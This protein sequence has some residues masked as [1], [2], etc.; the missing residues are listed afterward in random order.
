MVGAQKSSSGVHPVV[1]NTDA[2]N[3]PTLQDRNAKDGVCIGVFTDEMA[4]YQRFALKK[5][6]VRKQEEWRFR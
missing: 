6:R 4:G 5:S 3:L 1:G 2:S